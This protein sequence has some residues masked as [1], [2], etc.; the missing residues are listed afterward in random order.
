[1]PARPKQRAELVVS[2]IRQQF[3][4]LMW[5]EGRIE[6]QTFNN[7]QAQLALHASTTDD[8]RVQLELTP[9]IHHG[10]YQQR[11]VPGEAMFRLDSRRN[12]Q[13][14]E[15]LT[16]RAALAPGQVLVLGSHRERQ[17]SL[18]HCFF[19]DASANDQGERLLLLRLLESPR[20]PLFAS[21]EED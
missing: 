6:G 19:H 16:I 14:M 4:A 1:M 10:N 11:Y 9:E 21:S 2:S 7:G 18:G 12:R 8:A 20:D 13:A 3:H 15:D 5:K 17:G